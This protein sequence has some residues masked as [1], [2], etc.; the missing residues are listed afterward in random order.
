MRWPAW[1]SERSQKVAKGGIQSLRVLP[2]SK[3]SR[4]WTHGYTVVH[5]GWTKLGPLM[6]RSQRRPWPHI[7]FGANL[8]TK[9]IQSTERTARWDTTPFKDTIANGYNRPW[10]GSVH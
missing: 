9:S 1:P 7:A 6:G 4:R 8:T 2:P 5:G 10:E 3:S